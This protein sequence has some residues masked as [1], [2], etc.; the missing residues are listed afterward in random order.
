MRQ[1]QPLQSYK[2]L[3]YSELQQFYRTVMLPR[4]TTG[5]PVLGVYFIR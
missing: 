4:F 2:S 5:F 3:S 1:P